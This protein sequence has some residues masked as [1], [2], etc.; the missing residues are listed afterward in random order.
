VKTLINRVTFLEEFV[1]KIVWNQEAVAVQNPYTPGQIL[2]MAVDN[3]KKLGLYSEDCR[4]WDRKA[5]GAKD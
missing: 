3:I 1:E 5:T 2:L 4:D